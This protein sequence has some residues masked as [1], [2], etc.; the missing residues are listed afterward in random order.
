MDLELQ[1][2]VPG[3]NRTGLF[4][5]LPFAA[6]CPVWNPVLGLPFTAPRP[7]WNPRVT[8][9]SAADT[10][11]EPEQ[12]TAGSGPTMTTKRGRVQA[13]AYST[14]PVNPARFRFTLL[15]RSQIT[16]NETRKSTTPIAEPSAQVPV[17]PN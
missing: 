2:V 12:W 1:P 5:G 10:S 9:A 6:P 13:T 3:L 8:R 14:A 7:A 15:N 11:R 17:A 4:L 16:S